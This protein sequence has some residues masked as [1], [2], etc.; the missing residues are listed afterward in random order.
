MNKYILSAFI[1][2][3][4]ITQIR[5]QESRLPDSYGEENYIYVKY[6]SLCIDQETQSGSLEIWLDNITD[7][8]NS[9]LMDIYLP[10]GFSIA[11]SEGSDLYNVQPNNGNKTSDHAIRIAEREGFYRILGYSITGSPIAKGND[12]LL[13]FVIKIPDYFD[14]TT[15]DI[16]IKIKNISI[17]AGVSGEVAHCFP[18]IEGIDFTKFLRGDANDNGSVNV[19]DV[20][21]IGDYIAKKEVASFSFANA[22]V[23]EDLQ[24]TVADINGV[25][26]IIQNTIPT[27]GVAPKKVKSMSEDRLVSD[28]FTVTSADDFNID[29]KLDNS[30]AYSSLQAS[31]VIP[32]GMT[33]QKVSSGSRAAAHNLIYNFTEDN[34]V[35]VVLFSLTNTPFADSEENLFTLTVNAKADCG[36]LEMRDIHASDAMSNDY[37]LS[38]AGGKNEGVTTGISG[39]DTMEFNIISHP[40]G[41]EL[42]NAEGTTITIC[43]IAGQTIAS[44]RMASESERFFLDKGVYIVIVNGKSTKIII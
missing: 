19:A 34:T 18:D 38:Y 21:T 40:D 12:M 4:S 16:D 8:F 17:A 44:R 31:V 29:I 6:N 39:I 26:N 1:S 9:Y 15:S 27:L 36:D 42:T 41:I 33:V 35:E 7:D 10:E 23:N 25:V 28:N 14:T 2:L 5:A 43:N 13:K 24:I 37:V 20:V 30:I 3:I 22:D 11:K 32:E